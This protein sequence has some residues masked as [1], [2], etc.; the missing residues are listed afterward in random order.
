MR[1]LHARP[2][3]PLCVLQSQRF[4]NA[5]SFLSAYR[6]PFVQSIRPGTRLTPQ[7]LEAFLPLIHRFSLMTYDYDGGVGGGGGV[8]NSPF[9]WIRECVQT[10]AP[11][12]GSELRSK[13]LLGIPFYGGFPVWQLYLLLM[14]CG[15]DQ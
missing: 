8:P 1:F 13:V 12:A 7:Q 2:K 15:M 14:C 3:L 6:Q 9:G 4:R 11:Q 5:G 10:L